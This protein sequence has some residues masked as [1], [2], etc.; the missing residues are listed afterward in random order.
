[1]FGRKA[2]F[3]AFLGAVATVSSAHAGTTTFDFGNG[4]PG[5]DS[6]SL[7]MDVNGHY[8]TAYGFNANGSC[9]DLEQFDSKHD[10]GL[11]VDDNCSKTLTND[12][13]G[14]IEN[15][16]TLDICSLD[17]LCGC[18]SIEADLLNCHTSFDVYGSNK[19]GTLGKDLVCDSTA[20]DKFVDVNNWNKY[21]Y[22]SIAVSP[23]DLKKGCCGCDEQMLFRAVELKPCCCTAIPLPAAAYSG[24]AG[25]GMLGLMQVGG[26]FRKLAA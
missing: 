2:L 14:C 25:L 3:A 24:L 19:L 21:M 23:E 15:F 9:A 5:K 6:H 20:S 26:K 18:L 17:K 13:H 11:G 16:I 1:M 4:K 12:C 8:I 22:L 10:K 7:N